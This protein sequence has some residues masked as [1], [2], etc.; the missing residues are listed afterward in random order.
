MKTKTMTSV[1]KEHDIFVRHSR[2]QQVLFGLFIALTVLA[3]IW[4]GTKKALAV[5]PTLAYIP[6]QINQAWCSLC[7]SHSRACM[8]QVSSLIFI[9]TFFRL[10]KESPCLIE[11]S[12][13]DFNSLSWMEMEV[14]SVWMSFCIRIDLAVNN[15]VTRNIRQSDS[16]D[17][18]PFLVIY[19]SKNFKKKRLLYGK[20]TAV[21]STVAGKMKLI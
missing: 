15:L 13:S 14:M 4:P 9:Y 2:K 3:M 5:R 16:L 10:A 8:W 18:P 12:N 7:E 17:N 6:V 19:Q 1:A 20:N 11:R 21:K